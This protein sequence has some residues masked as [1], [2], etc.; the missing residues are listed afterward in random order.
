MFQNLK[1]SRPN[2]A[3]KLDFILK[4]TMYS[5]NPSNLWMRVGPKD[6]AKKSEIGNGT[7]TV[8]NGELF[9]GGDILEG[10]L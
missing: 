8:N 1:Y 2:S 9:P 6:V 10:A 7:W 5:K 3:R 4:Y